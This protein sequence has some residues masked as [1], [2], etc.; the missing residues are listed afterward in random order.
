MIWN[1]QNI[2]HPVHI[3]LRDAQCIMYLL[4]CR[5]CMIYIWFIMYSVRCKHI[6]NVF[7]MLCMMYDA[8]C[9]VIWVMIRFLRRRIDRESCLP[10]QDLVQPLCVCFFVLL[11]RQS[12][13][14]FIKG[15]KSAF[16]K[17][18]FSIVFMK[19]NFSNFFNLIIWNYQKFWYSSYLLMYSGVQKAFNF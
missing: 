18:A 1:L 2:V 19:W 11:L 15:R 6:Y 14:M 13:E 17:N 3:V 4:C 5:W 16:N 7:T 10:I 8:M 9:V 12:L